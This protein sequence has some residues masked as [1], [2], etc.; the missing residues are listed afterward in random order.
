[1]RETR[2]NKKIEQ[3]WKRLLKDG[4]KTMVI[5]L[6]LALI[7]NLV[8]QLFQNQFDWI[9]PINYMLFWETELYLLGSIVLL[10]IYFWLFSLIGNRWISAELLFTIVLLAGIATQQ[11]MNVREEPLYPSDLAMITDLPFILQM[12][13]WKLVVIF[14]VLFILICGFTIKFILK[15]KKRKQ[16]KYK[17]YKKTRVIVRAAVFFVTSTMLVYIGNFN[18]SENKVKEAFDS[19]A[20]W[21]TFSQKDNYSNNG[22]IP[23]FLYNLKSPAMEEPNDYSKT[24]ITEIID[25]YTQK[26]E[27]INQSR[28]SELKDVNI[29]YV[30]NESFSDPYA[31]EGM[32][33]SEDPIPLIRKQMKKHISGKA[34]SQGYGGGTANIEFEALTGVSMEALAPSITTPYIQMTTKMDKLPSMLSYLSQQDYNLTAIHPFNTSMYKRK[35]VYQRMG[36]STFLSEEN[37][38]NQ[39]VIDHNR[40][41]SDDSAYQEVSLQLEKTTET[42]F[43]HLVTMQNHTTYTGKYP[44]TV[45]EAEGSADD[46]EAKNYYQDIAYSD[47][48]LEDFLD[49][50]D[51]YPEDTLLVFWGDHLPGFYGDEIHSLNGRVVMHE[52]PLL[53]YT[54][55]DQEERYI[56]TISPIYFMNHILEKTNAPVTPYYALLMSLEETL[57]A[58]EKGIYLEGPAREFRETRKELT[59]ETLEI[60]KDY[61][62]IIYDISTGKNYSGSTDFFGGN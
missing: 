6:V 58:F 51:D 37:M 57:P 44:G 50:L 3:G 43:I 45:L 24:K 28:T 54:N 31:L 7:S 59:P 9:E 26:A 47:E 55:F 27:L 46:E 56:D 21:I 36:F 13:D 2:R 19:G 30:M 39:K 48:A 14:I 4:F 11:K 61:D 10:I 25:E 60:L 29:I 22:F 40:Y 1:M 38:K 41:I 35:D 32:T 42:D 20:Y 16:D 53:I 17:E 23:G 33:V 12:V 5:G 8:L 15:N 34:L 52:T 49:Y 62:N 18:Q